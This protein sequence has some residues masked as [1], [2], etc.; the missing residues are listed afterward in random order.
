MSR[1]AAPSHNPG[2]E[3]NP[4]LTRKEMREREREAQQS[5]NQ[6][7]SAKRP[8]KTPVVPVLADLFS[9][10]SQP[11]PEEQQRQPAAVEPR[12]VVAVVLPSAV[13]TAPE[14]VESQAAAAASEPFA[15]AVPEIVTATVDRP[16]SV[17]SAVALPSRRSMRTKA[18]AV[19]SVPA[20]PTP[21][22][23]APA[24]SVVVSPAPVSVAPPVVA[25]GAPTV[26]ERLFTAPIS[27]VH[28]PAAATA[29]VDPAPSEPQSI[30]ADAPFDIFGLTPSTVTSTSDASVETLESNA[31]L[32]VAPTSRKRSRP[33][34]AAQS[35]RAPKQATAATAPR[36]RKATNSAVKSKRVWVSRKALAPSNT[37]GSSSKRSASKALS[38]VAML[39]AFPILV[40][41]SV[42]SNIFM[43]ADSATIA[44]GAPVADVAALSAN[45]RASQSL[46]VSDDVAGEVA[47][48]DDI[49]VISYAEVLA[50]KYAGIDYEYSATSGDVR[51]P[52]PYSVPITDG[53]GDRVGGFHKGT[54]F[55]AASGTPIYAIADGTVDLIQADW[56]GY[57]YHAVISH[58][59][60]GQQVTSLYAHMITDSSPVVVGQQVK[61]GDFLGLVGETGIA[62]G[63]HLH[64]EVH[65]DD[66][67]VDPYAWLTANAVD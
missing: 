66:V 18:A 67:P 58:T 12:P 42:P 10:H 59:I 19:A 13:E 56:S 1:D 57:G 63:A 28:A 26:S 38:F 36:S 44:A 30:G 51:W 37:S 31:A 40:G 17:E 52:F 7:S 61:A 8:A 55:A 62:Y 34:K 15:V 29:A 65:L 22:F 43:D 50:L 24:S 64:F 4:P 23:P 45:A 20:I 60:N 5:A 33:A 11:A 9:P 48:H 54:D 14:S 2:T 6:R 32:A 46:A 21:A 39:F 16:V 41:V 3:A 53:F 47:A 25:P 35:G 49:K 27:T